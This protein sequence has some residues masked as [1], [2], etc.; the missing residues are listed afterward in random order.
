M[1]DLDLV[2]EQLCAPS[3][4]ETV[5]H[6]PLHDSPMPSLE[7][8]GEIMSRLKATLFPGYFGVSCVH[9]ESM[10]HHL[11]AN[12]D[13]IFRKLAE[14]IR[15]GGCFACASYATDCMSC[16]EVSMRK[17]MEFM[18]R[19]PHIRRLLASDAKAAY[20][21]DPAATCR[22]E[23]MLAYPA[24]EAISIFR[25]AHELYLM[26][27]PMLPR[28]MTEYAHSLTGI[29]IH[30]GAT[31]G[32]YFFIDHGTGVVIGE[33]TVIGERVKLYQGVTLGAKSFAVQSDGTLVK[34][35]KRHPNIGSNV[36]IYAGATILGGDTYIGD[37]C[38]IGGNV[39]L[40]H[41]VEPGK[42]VLTAREQT[43]FV[44]TDI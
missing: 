32:P 16:E 21:G 1:P 11:S 10:R 42:R 19:L 29:D 31:I 23:V 9:V 40:T 44:T 8:L 36:V 41:S 25:I 7:E 12:L 24:F 5:L 3:S 27:V 39:W 38:V 30:P 37:N 15:R 22:E 43:E 18:Q 2:V 6:H 35:N 4:L 17:A 20:E 13:S 33:T 34:G 14:Q 26:R 28:M